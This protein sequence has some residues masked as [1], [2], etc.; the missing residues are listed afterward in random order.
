MEVHALISNQ[1]DVWLPVPEVLSQMHVHS[2]HNVRDFQKLAEEHAIETC[3]LIARTGES[4]DLFNP[5]MDY[6]WISSKYLDAVSSL[7]VLNLA[8]GFC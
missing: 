8:P 6:T 3:D 4:T 5:F 1:G 2:M 7:R